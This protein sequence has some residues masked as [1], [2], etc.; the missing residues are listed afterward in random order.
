M[1]KK[2][3]LD[4]DYVICDSGYLALLNEF[5][6]K[7]YKLEDFKLAYLE[8]EVIKSEAERKKFYKFMADKNPLE[9]T[10]IYAD[11][12]KVIKKLYDKYDL[13]ICSNCAVEGFKQSSG[14]HFKFKYEFLIKN[15]PYIDIKKFILT[16]SKNL[17]DVDIQIDDN[18]KHLQNNTEQKFLYTA[19][20]NKNYTDEYLKQNN[21]TRVNSWKEIAD[22][23]L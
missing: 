9:Y 23:L 14:N 2:L 20:Y 6:K 3:L 7:N 19:Y 18:I 4:V 8:E 15:F 17:F 21:I 5:T 22:L 11:A 1:K 12:K 16:G 13:Y 10:E